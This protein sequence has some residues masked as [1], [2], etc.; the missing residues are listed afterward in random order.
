MPKHQIN[1]EL[2]RCFPYKGGTKPGKHRLLSNG[3]LLY[4]F[5]HLATIFKI[6]PNTAKVKG[7][8]SLVVQ[9]QHRCRCE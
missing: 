6:I 5:T 3:C 7:K 2:N 9:E 8:G 1:W 4:P